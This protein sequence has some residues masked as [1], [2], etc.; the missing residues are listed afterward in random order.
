MKQNWYLIFHIVAGVLFI[1]GIIMCGNVA[2]ATVGSLCTS[3]GFVFLGLGT[4]FSRKQRAQEEQQEENKE[5][6]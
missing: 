6:K 4:H 3:A 5:D 1:G 2:T